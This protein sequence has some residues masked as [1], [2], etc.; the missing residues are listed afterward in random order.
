MDDRSSIRR[1]ECPQCGAPL[2]SMVCAFCGSA[3]VHGPDG[4]LTDFEVAYR[5][6]LEASAK[7]GAGSGLYIGPD[8]WPPL[9]TGALS[10]RQW[11]NRHA[12]GVS[13]DVAIAHDVAGWMDIG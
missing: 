2:A 12:R 1:F 13:P 4:P 9:L 5:A 7:Y 10:V 3:L 8:F 11:Y 6:G